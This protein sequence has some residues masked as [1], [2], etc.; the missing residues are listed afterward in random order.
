MVYPFGP[1][2]RENRL[3]AVP[4]DQAGRTVARPHHTYYFKGELARPSIQYR[5]ALESNFEP[6]HGSAIH[7]GNRVGTVIAV[8]FHADPLLC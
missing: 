4:T 2:K 5:Q 6:L 8:K 7:Q 1:L 3:S